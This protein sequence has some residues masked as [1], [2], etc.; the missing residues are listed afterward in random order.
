MAPSATITP[1]RVW[2]P[3]K[4]Q[5]GVALQALSLQARASPHPVRKLLLGP[6][7][8]GLA[9]S[10]CPSRLRPKSMYIDMQLRFTLR[11]QCR[12]AY[13]KCH[14]ELL[15]YRGRGTQNG[16]S[17]KASTWTDLPPDAAHG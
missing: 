12:S 13:S 2:G 6:G 11:S 17:G 15:S 8:Q 3:G 16:T 4:E 14:P 5:A 1:V 9:L 10:F 7:H